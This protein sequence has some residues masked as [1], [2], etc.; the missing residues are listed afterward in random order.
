MKRGDVRRRKFGNNSHYSLSDI[1]NSIMQQS[2]SLRG[3][4]SDKEDLNRSLQQPA[5]YLSEK[6]VSIYLS[7][8]FT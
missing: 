6:K 7:N 1:G 4:V 8:S 2:S 3:S 5:P